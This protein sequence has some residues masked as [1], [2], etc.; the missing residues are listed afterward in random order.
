MD[1][2]L[3]LGGVG[4]QISEHCVAICQRR[5]VRHWIRFW[6]QRWRIKTLASAPHSPAVGDIVTLTQRGDRYAVTIN[7]QPVLTWSPRPKGSDA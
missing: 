3:P 4:L 6:R 7:D 1:V 5:R 2:G